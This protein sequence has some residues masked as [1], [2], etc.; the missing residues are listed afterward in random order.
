[1]HT[2]ALAPHRI[3][4][5]LAP[6]VDRT[7]LA[8]MLAGRDGG[9][10][11]LSQR[12]GGVAATGFLVDLRTRLAA[13]GGTVDGPGFTAI[14][15]YQDP[16]TCRRI[17]D[18]QVAHGMIHRSPAG[19]LSATERGAAFS[20]S[21]T[22]CTP[23]SPRN[24]GPGTTSGWPG[25]W[26]CSADSWRTP[27]CWPTRRAT[28]AVRP[29]PR[30]RPVRAGRHHVGRPAAQPARHPAVPPG[31]RA[32]RRLGCRR[33]HRVEHRRPAG[34]SRTARHRVG[35]RPSGRRPVRRARR[36]G[37]PDHAR[38]PGGVARLTG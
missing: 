11:E 26:R 5:L 12:Y 19:A 6:A 25:W 3:A 36:G 24:C 23:R 18:K 14:T 2:V 21:C 15:R 22:R 32:R 9:G 1:M 17:V 37:A 35:D 33:A 34:R 8:G 27:W 13:P 31:R 28:R 30:W 7:F 16:T 10:A 4:G 38:R 20:P 29:S